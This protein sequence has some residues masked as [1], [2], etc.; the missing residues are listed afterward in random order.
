[1]ILDICH[2]DHREHRGKAVSQLPKVAT[3][4]VLSYLKATNLKRA[5]WINFGMSRLID[6]VQRLVV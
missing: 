5:L 1:M 3:A 6:G 4:Q 2:R